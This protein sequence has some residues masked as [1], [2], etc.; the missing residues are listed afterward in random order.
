MSSLH[1]SSLLPTYRCKEEA[2]GVTGMKAILIRKRLTI[3]IT[4]CTQ[5]RLALFRG[6][7]IGYA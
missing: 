5:S 3:A 4:T 2:L 6:E 7:G 1:D